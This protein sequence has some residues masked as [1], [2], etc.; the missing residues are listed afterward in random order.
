[1]SNLPPIHWPGPDGPDESSENG[2]SQKASPTSIAGTIAGTI[3]GAD[4]RMIWLADESVD[5]ILEA[6]LE[7]NRV[8]RTPRHR[9]IAEHLMRAAD[10]GE[11]PDPVMLCEA[12]VTVLN[13]IQVN[14]HCPHL[15]LLLSRLDWLRRGD[16]A[17]SHWE[18]TAT[19]ED[20]DIASAIGEFDEPLRDGCT[21]VRFLCQCKFAAVFVFVHPH[22]LPMDCVKGAAGMLAG[23]LC[24]CGGCYSL[25]DCRTLPLNT[26]I[27]HG[28]AKKLA[29]KLIADLLRELPGIAPVGP[30]VLPAAKP[31]PAE[32]RS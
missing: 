3:A 13:L 21:L 23:H 19:I 22:D 10:A 32:A 11:N 20:M 7:L 12:I 27:K 31:V 26:V 15:G 5:A 25:G 16:M 18:I 9:E 24:E 6:A 8:G 17:M 4:A 2:A 30:I 29:A 28:N 14:P 1:M